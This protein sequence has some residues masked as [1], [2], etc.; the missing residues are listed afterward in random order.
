MVNDYRWHDLRANPADVPQEDG[1]YL[2]FIEYSSHKGGFYIIT[3]WT[4]GWNCWRHAD[5]TI[6]RAN[7]IRVTAWKKIE[8][9]E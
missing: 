6:E 8:P 9:F 2:T 4:E 1:N 7:E 5:G 3:E